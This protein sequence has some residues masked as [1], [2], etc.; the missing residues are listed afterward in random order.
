MENFAQWFIG[1][2]ICMFLTQKSY[3]KLSPTQQKFY[4]Q[5]ATFCNW[6]FI[7]WRSLFGICFAFLI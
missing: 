5:N 1:Y 7:F 6:F 3:L 4:E 2:T